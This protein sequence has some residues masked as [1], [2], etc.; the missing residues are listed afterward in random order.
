MKIIFICISCFLVVGLAVAVTSLSIFDK[1]D[2]PYVKHVFLGEIGEIV[3]DEFDVKTKCN[4]QIN[5]HMV[6]KS[7]VYNEYEDIL[8]NRQLPVSIELQVDAYDEGVFENVFREVKSPKVEGLGLNITSL[9]FGNVSLARGHYRIKA[10]VLDGNPAS[11]HDIDFILRVE[12]KPK[13][14]CEN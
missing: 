8:I 1:V 9:N 13:I 10:E 5:F 12:V 4:Y 7:K 14:T 2:A 6:H 3:N 11:L